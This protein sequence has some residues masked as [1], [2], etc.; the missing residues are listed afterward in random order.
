MKHLE[1]HSAYGKRLINMSQE[2]FVT[3]IFIFIH[4]ETSA[5]VLAKM[6]EQWN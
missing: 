2:P 5:Y 4:Q 6:G 1:E 3:I